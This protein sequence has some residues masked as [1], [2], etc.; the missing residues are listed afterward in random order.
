[1]I[2]LLEF[3]IRLNLY[4]D[5]EYKFYK[6]KFELYFLVDDKIWFDLNM[7]VIFYKMNYNL[8]VIGEM[9]LYVCLCGMFLIMNKLLFSLFNDNVEF[10][11]NVIYYLVLIGKIVYLIFLD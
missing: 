5:Y 10:R 4:F 3:F 9:K 1:M 2:F 6:D 8:I 11:K 7:N